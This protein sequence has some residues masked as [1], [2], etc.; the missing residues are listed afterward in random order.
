ME[1]ILLQLVY[2]LVKFSCVDGIPDDQ[3]NDRK[4]SEDDEVIHV[5]KHI[6]KTNGPEHPHQIGH[7][8]HIHQESKPGRDHPFRVKKR[9]SKHPDQQ[10]H[11]DELGCIPKKNVKC[12]KNES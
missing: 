5:R 8:I 4:N 11:T 3:E 2:E 12:G 1:L 7:G 9:G 10:E 6:L